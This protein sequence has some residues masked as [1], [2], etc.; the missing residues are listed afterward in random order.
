MHPLK[1]YSSN[2]YWCI[3]ILGLILPPIISVLI[4]FYFFCKYRTKQF[5]IIFFIFFVLFVSY[6][7][8]SYDNTLRVWSVFHGSDKI[9]W[10]LGDPLTNIIRY[11]LPIGLESSNFFYGY[12]LCIYIFWML[13][14]YNMQIKWDIPVV[15]IC[16]FGMILRNAVDLVYYTL[17]VSFLL[18]IVSKKVIRFKDY[19]YIIPVL[20]IFHPGVFFVFL[21]AMLLYYVLKKSKSYI[22]YM[23]L[24]GIAIFYFFIGNIKIPSFGIPIIDEIAAS[25]YNYIDADNI[26]GKQE[27]DFSGMTFFMQYYCM[28]FWYIVIFIFTI[29]Y[30]DKMKQKYIIAIYQVATIASICMLN[31]VTLMERSMVILSLASWLCLILLIKANVFSVKNP[32]RKYKVLSAIA[33]LIFLLNVFRFTS[34]PLGDVFNNDSYKKIQARS[35][36]VPS[37]VLFDTKN[38]GFSDDYVMQNSSYFFR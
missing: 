14:V 23:V 28:M 5:G 6:N 3:L 7:I 18:Y 17:A 38:F 22:Y 33:V 30:R 4:S 8:Y 19:L 20:Y 1:S 10:L 26:W 35:Y 12:I 36:Y 16:I 21:P 29:K 37:L 32:L 11:F 15:L 2:R 24:I 9:S 31:Y 25:L 34:I 13:T 27:R